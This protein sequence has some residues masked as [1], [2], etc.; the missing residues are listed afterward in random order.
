MERSRDNINFRKKTEIAKELKE[1]R[2]KD[3][4]RKGTYVLI[5]S[6]YPCANIIKDIGDQV[7]FVWKRRETGGFGFLIIDES[8]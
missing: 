1:L 4:S 7:H 2:E 5:D 6:I 8:R 3:V